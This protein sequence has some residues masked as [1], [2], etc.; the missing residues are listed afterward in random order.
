M[1]T[2]PTEYDS[3]LEQGDST[4]LPMCDPKPLKVTKSFGNMLTSP[5]AAE[6]PGSG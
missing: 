3:D 5:I 2:E 4:L 6:A 1:G